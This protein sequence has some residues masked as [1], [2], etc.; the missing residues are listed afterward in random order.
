MNV[1]TMHSRSTPRSLVRAILLIPAVLLLAN[2]ARAHDEADYQKLLD[3]NSS[4]IVTV[5]FVL[6]IKS[7]WGENESEQEVSGVVIGADG[8]VMCANSHLTG[9]A[10]LQR[11]GGTATPSD[12][13]VLIGDD[14]E[15]KNAKVIARDTEL[16]LAWL[17][18]EDLGDKKLPVID[19]GKAASPKIGDT[20]YTVSRLAKYFDRL[21]VVREARVGGITTKPRK[22]YVPSSGGGALGLPVF[23][24]EGHVVGVTITL[25]PD[26]EEME[27]S[28]FVGGSMLI[29]PIEEVTKATKR[30]LD[31]T[32]DEEDQ[33]DEN[34]QAE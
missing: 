21:A 33:T 1:R 26:A 19:M 16:D 10:W 3:D 20:L 13:K 11:S 9:G 29:L 4:A 25:T 5:K 15:G 24:A 18:I 17:R 34:E 2:T 12:V 28:G 32:R 22:L 23:D 31:S 8:L 6:K 7:S 30:A 27:A 14:T